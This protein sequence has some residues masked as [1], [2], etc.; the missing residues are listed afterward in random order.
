MKGIKVALLGIAGAV[1]VTASFS[2]T[3]SAAP[4]S[5]VVIRDVQASTM[6]YG[7]NVSAVEQPNTEVEPSVAV[8][9]GDPADVV[10]AFQE[11]RH[12]GGGARDNGFAS[13]LDHGQTW[14]FGNLPGLTKAA[15]NPIS[16]TGNCPTAPTSSAPF[17]RASDAAVA[18]GK[19][20]TG[21]A[22]GGYFAYVNSLV[23]D[24]VTCGSNPSGMGINV[25]SDG[26]LTW[27]SAILQSDGLNGLND[28]NWV[29]VD[30]GSGLGHHTG[31][32]YV[33]WDK[34]LASLAVSYCDPDVAAS[35]VTG[36]GCDK[37]AN[38][39]S[40]NNTSWYAI[41]STVEGIGAFPVVLTDGS[42]GV[43]FFDRVTGGPC[44]TMPTDQSCV[45]SGDVA[46]T[47]IPKA[48][49]AVWPGPLPAT[50]GV[51]DITPLNTNG[52]LDQRAGGLP[53]V[54]VDPNTD[55][56]Y[57][58]WEDNRFRT[59]SSSSSQNDA[60]M[61]SSK[62]DM[63]TGL[64]GLSV[65]SWSAPKVINPGPEN[66][67]IDHWNTTVAVGQDSI[68][69]V[70]YRQRDETPLTY[71]P[72]HT[73][74]NTYYQ[75]SR[76]AGA[77]FSPQLLVNTSVTD[78]PGFGAFDI[79]NCSGCSFQGDYNQIAAGGTDESYVSRDESYAPTPG[80]PC[81]CSFTGPPSNNQWQQTWVAFIAPQPGNGVPEFRF[82]PLLGGI[83]AAVGVAALLR[84][85]RRRTDLSA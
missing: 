3:G 61:I 25:S 19:D 6:P 21:A 74:I 44:T 54:A 30:N 57:L 18:F 69:R 80:A 47:L 68:V 63:V 56:V 71:S 59:E 62:P 8:N 53:Q 11:G 13:S 41:N 14:T 16:V 2:S 67:H 79:T 10:T 26:G 40:V 33:V 32:V 28:K 78:E 24:D 70:A 22:H 38:W 27:T 17:D 85:R 64:P 49:N 37:A 84:R 55:E 4:G 58:V 50:S 83:G 45:A 42:L 60:V 43:S 15:P 51:I 39:S 46:W 82:V 12:N 35:I 34:V 81:A 48:G 73:L 36:K 75:E 72:L 9:P 52:V 66:N 31:R 5:P 20:P 23:F 7:T 1:L 76:D 77:T 65:G 29:V